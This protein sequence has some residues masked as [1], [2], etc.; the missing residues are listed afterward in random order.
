MAAVDAVRVSRVRTRRLAT[1]VREGGDPGGVP[2]LFVHGN[3]SSGRVW[4]DQ[5]AALPAGLRGIAPDLRGYGGTERRTVD[6]T[7]G[8]RDWSDDLR[9]LVEALGLGPVHLVG[10]SMGAGVVLQYAIDHPAD[11]RSVALV[12]PMSPYGFGGTKDE[13]GTPCHPDFAGSGAGTV[14]PELP[15]RIAAGER[16]ARDL[17]SPRTVV[18]SLFFPSPALVRD[19]EALLDD[20]LATAVGPGN[21]PGDRAPSPNWPH[22]APGRRG[23]GNAFSP[24]WCDL[25]GFAASGCRAPAL[26]VRGALDAVIGDSSPLDFAVLGRAGVVPGWPGPLAYPPQP[27][28]AQTRAVLA[29]YA[30]NG[31]SYREEVLAG[32][33]HFP[34]VQEPERVARLLAQHLTAA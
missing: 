7:R 28:L 25:S 5:L 22:V 14:N 15:R 12:A 8:M 24:R 29:R 3:V 17:A 1:A 31:G 10:H 20:V 27:M 9:A 11:V 23:V 6:A 21:Y 4:S 30:A 34:A 33:G 26:W 13:R 16:V 18:R 19:E 32:V 2:V